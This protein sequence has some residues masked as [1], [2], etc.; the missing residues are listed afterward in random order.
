MARA[1]IEPYITLMIFVCPKSKVEEAVAAHGPSH[2]V[3]LLGA[4]AMI[5]TPAGVACARHLKLSVNDIPAP[6]EGK[7]APGADHVAELLAFTEDWTMEAP[8]LIHCWAGISRSTAAAYIVACASAPTADEFV[9]AKT[10]RAAAPHAQPNPLLI[11]HADD[12]L[13]RD[14]RMMD[15]IDAIGEATCVVEG[16]IFPFKIGAAA[17]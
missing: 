1:G 8:M 16:P 6:E 17:R 14:G 4:E 10:L 11:A 13:G 5:D 15:A 12:L 2:L 7:V 9:L 3:S